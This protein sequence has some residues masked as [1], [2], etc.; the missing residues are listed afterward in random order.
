MNDK[1]I[2]SKLERWKFQIGKV[3]KSYGLEVDDVIKYLQMWEGFKKWSIKNGVGIF[4]NNVLIN[5]TENSED[6]M[7]EFE[8]DYFAKPKI[9]T[10]IEVDVSASNQEVINEL[11]KS[12]EDMNGQNFYKGK[13]RVVGT[14]WTR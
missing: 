12:I 2:I 14:R 13:I 7:D 4:S 10:V 1:E 9:K 8:K 6:L 11:A 5:L 3:F